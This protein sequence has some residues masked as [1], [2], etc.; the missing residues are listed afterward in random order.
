MVPGALGD[1]P[2]PRNVTTSVVNK[3]VPRHSCG[4][5]FLPY[6]SFNSSLFILGEKVVFLGWAVNVGVC[7]TVFLRLY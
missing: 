4:T 5:R 6:F 3:S 2:E 1:I 7:Q